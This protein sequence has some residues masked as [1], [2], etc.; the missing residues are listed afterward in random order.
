[1]KEVK[2]MKTELQVSVIYLKDDANDINEFDFFIRMFP[3]EDKKCISVSA[4]PR[5]SINEK[6]V[7]HIQFSINTVKDLNAY[8]VMRVIAQLKELEWIVC[9]KDLATEDAQTHL[10]EMMKKQVESYSKD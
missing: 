5:F 9:D 6:M 3:V 2:Q 7:K 1:M 10:M 4:M 8:D